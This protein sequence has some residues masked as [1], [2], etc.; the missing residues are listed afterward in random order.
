[1][2]TT[3]KQKGKGID[4][5]GDVDSTAVVGI[6]G[7]FTPRRWARGKE[8]AEGENSVGDVYRAGGV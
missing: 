4:R 3:G 7:V 2:R 5:I 1:M 6:S 8:V